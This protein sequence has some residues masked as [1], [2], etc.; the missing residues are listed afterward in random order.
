ME[1][2]QL[3][4]QMAKKAEPRYRAVG[5]NGVRSDANSSTDEEMLDI[6]TQMPQADYQEYSDLAD[7]SQGKQIHIYFIF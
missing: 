2:D 6:T 5:A 7:K 4:T 3:V 1:T